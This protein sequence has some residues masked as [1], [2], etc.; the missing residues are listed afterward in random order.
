MRGLFQEYES[1]YSD[2][3]SSSRPSQRPRSSF[4]LGID[5]SSVAAQRLQSFF[6]NQGTGSNIS[7]E[8]D[9]Y[10]SEPKS[11]DLAGEGPNDVDVLQWWSRRQNQYPILAMMAREIL[12]V[13][14]ST[15]SVEQA[16][17]VGGYVLDERRSVMTPRN[18]EAQV[19]LKDYTLAEMREQENNWDEIFAEYPI[20]TTEA[21]STDTDSI[22][23]T[24]TDEFED[25][26]DFDADING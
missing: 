24:E 18:L 20:S 7:S 15:V 5:S 11:T 21:E 6:Q 16:F 26:W 2:R 13:P 23:T 25:D 1:K 17:S 14:A 19:L 9:I 8:L 3:G 4:N 10:L 22:A 12:A